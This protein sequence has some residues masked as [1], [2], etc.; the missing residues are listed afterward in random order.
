MRSWCA[1][2]LL[3]VTGVSS[4]LA[5]TAPPDSVM[6]DHDYEFR[7]GI[8]DDFTAL[9]ANRPSRSWTIT[10]SRVVRLADD[11]RLQVETDTPQAEAVTRAYA[12]VV[13]GIPYLRGRWERARN[14]IE[15]AGLR[16]RGTL[17][18]LAY[19][20]LVTKSFEVK[21]YNPATG[22]PFRRGTVQRTKRQ[23]VERVL[24]FRTGQLYPM[25]RENLLRLVAKDA[26]LRRAI[27]ALPADKD[28][29]D[30]L[31]RALKIYDERYPLW[32]PR[33]S[34]P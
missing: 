30:R 17:C 10:G 2:L 32:M 29:P 26:E 27:A 16:V 24:D 3:V 22:K 5:Q 31:F 25:N 6:L 33:P 13:D 18:Y 12:V 7:D 4:G 15:F 19:D 8:Y 1:F 21:A 11:Y 34:A 23:A 20:T 9:R 14:F 28:L